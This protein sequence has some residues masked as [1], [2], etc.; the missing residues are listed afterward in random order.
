MHS[1]CYIVYLHFEQR[2]S[3]N[4]FSKSGTTTQKFKFRCNCSAN[5]PSKISLIFINLS[6]L[7]PHLV[8]K[9]RR[10]ATSFLL[11]PSCCAESQDFRKHLALE[12]NCVYTCSSWRDVTSREISFDKIT[13]IFSVSSRWNF[14][15]F[16]RKFRSVEG[17]IEKKVRKMVN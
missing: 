2:R 4:P 6:P 17:K 14:M 8:S 9:A 3:S 1:T 13:K 7:P 12:G 16:A 5:F 15:I 10:N 11:F